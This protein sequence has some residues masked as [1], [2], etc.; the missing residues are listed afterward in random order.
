[1]KTCNPYML[2]GPRLPLSR[3]RSVFGVKI[4][5]GG[6][7]AAF[8][9]PAESCSGGHAGTQK[10][11]TCRPRKFPDAARGFSP[12]TSLLAES[13]ESC[14]ADHARGPGADT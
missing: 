14:P 1:M 9:D 12:V 10:C 7:A 8:P 3:L 13:A 5:P 2:S 4:V 6:A 11:C